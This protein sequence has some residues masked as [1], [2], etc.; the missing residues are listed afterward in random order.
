[1]TSRRICEP[2]SRCANQGDDVRH[3]GD[4]DRQSERDVATPDAHSISKRWIPKLQSDAD[5]REE[6]E[7]GGR[8][9]AQRDHAAADGRR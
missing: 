1:L 7:E 2:A 9:R 8:A 4:G 3:G 5:V 6:Q